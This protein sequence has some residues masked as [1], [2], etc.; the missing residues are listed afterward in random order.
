METLKC[1]GIMW[2]G[3]IQPYTCIDTRGG[4]CTSSSMGIW[5]H[6]CGSICFPEAIFP[7][8]KLLSWH[9]SKW[10]CSSTSTTEQTSLFFHA[11]FFFSKVFALARSMTEASI[12]DAFYFCFV[13]EG[14]SG[15][16]LKNELSTMLDICRCQ[17]Y[18]GLL[19]MVPVLVEYSH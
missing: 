11:Y 1:S 4:M 5:V 16:M 3:V 9:I 12:R 10:S 15:K 14:R 19:G 18:C 8:E 2:F 6:F 7:L 17:K 13:P